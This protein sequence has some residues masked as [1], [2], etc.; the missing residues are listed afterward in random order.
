MNRLSAESSADETAEFWRTRVR[1]VGHT[2][3]KQPVV[4]AFDQ[5]QR[6]RL[7][8]ERIGALGISRGVALDFGCGSGD[9]SRVLL[10]MGF[11][12]LAYDPFMAPGFSHPRLTYVGSAEAFWALKS[13]LSLIVSVTVLDH[14]LEAGEFA[15]L[16]RRFRA[17]ATPSARL[18][19]LEYAPDVDSPSPAEHQAYR[20]LP[21]WRQA[22]GEAG[23]GLSSHE[24]VSHPTEAPSHAFKRYQ[25]SLVT[26]L[27][28]RGLRLPVVAPATEWALAVH[29]GRRVARA[30]LERP[31]QSPL[32]LLSCVAAKGQP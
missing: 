19:A 3:W 17:L 21:T 6:V 29:A 9:F 11:E 4:Y 31:H 5:R 13:E 8:E 25:R 16:L 20:S 27:L 30:Q 32:K 23:W 7:L 1:R 26:R 24:P 22:L 28:G 2:G 15:R 12:V 10:K 18:M 14:V